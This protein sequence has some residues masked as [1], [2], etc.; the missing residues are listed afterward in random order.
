MLTDCVQTYRKLGPT[1]AEEF[2]AQLP[3]WCRMLGLA[4]FTLRHYPELRKYL[5]EGLEA[6]NLPLPDVG[7]KMVPAMLQKLAKRIEH[8]NKAGSL[9]QYDG[10]LC[11][12]SSNRKTQAIIAAG[13]EEAALLY[14]QFCL[15]DFYYN[16]KDAKRF[17]RPQFYEAVCSTESHSPAHCLH[18]HLHSCRGLLWNA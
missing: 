11:K 18:K 2:R 6:L 9:E 8:I 3:A 7:A 1:A 13:G 4:Y 14:Y 10:F 17:L 12:L 15:L 16:G 5:V